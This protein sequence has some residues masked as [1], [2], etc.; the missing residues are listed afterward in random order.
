MVAPARP[1][2]RKGCDTMDFATGILVLRTV[3][4][5]CESDNGALW[6]CCRECVASAVYDG[7]VAPAHAAFGDM[8]ASDTQLCMQC[9]MLLPETYADGYSE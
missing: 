1:P 9:N 2:D 4:T 5:G 8:R 3:G 7:M 6:F